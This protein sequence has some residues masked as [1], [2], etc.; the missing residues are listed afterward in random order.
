MQPG[1]RHYPHWARET[2][3]GQSERP[4]KGRDGGR[5]F[6]VGRT[7]EQAERPRGSPGGR[8]YQAHCGRTPAR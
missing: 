3:R 6:Q 1:N 8:C 2:A 7:Q 4:G 5:R